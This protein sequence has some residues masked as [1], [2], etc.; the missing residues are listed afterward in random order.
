[1]KILVC[2]KLTAQ[3]SFSAS[4]RDGGERLDGGRVGINPA[5]R[6]ALELAL[7]TKEKTPGAM[8]TVVAMAPEAAAYYLREALAMGA[9]SAVLVSDRRIA[10]SDT[11]VTSAVL[12]AAVRSLP[13]QD[14]IL[15]GKKAIDSE[16]GHVG[17]QLSVLLGLPL[18]TNVLSFEA[19]GGRVELLRAGERGQ[20]VYTGPLPCV[21]TVCNG[22]EMVREPGI[23]GLR[24]ARNVEI[25]RLSLDDLGLKAEEVGLDGSPTRT[26]KTEKLRFR[27][28]E[29]RR[30]EDAAQGAEALA[31]LLRGGEEAAP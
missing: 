4:L 3:S 13:A 22:N 17:P 10:G 12:A 29:G 11:L 2:L 26:V 6:C 7:R 21:L 9:D 15:C 30:I 16:T 5:D 23:L 19:A 8:V 27:S 18:A 31:A 14:L 1:M 25:T 28:V 24:R 20:R